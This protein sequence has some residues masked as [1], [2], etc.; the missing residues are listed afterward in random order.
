[1]ILL[2]SVFVAPDVQDTGVFYQPFKILALEGLLRRVSGRKFFAE[3]VGGG[4]AG[5]RTEGSGDAA[6]G[7]G[8]AG[9][10]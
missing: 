4:D 1:V 8:E 7:D 2:G 5:G 3:K 10:T 9:E 6:E